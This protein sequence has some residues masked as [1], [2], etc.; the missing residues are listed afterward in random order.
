MP[1]RIIKESICTSCEVDSLSA[2]EERFFYRLL[3]SCDDFGRID[4]RAEILRAK[5][6]PLKL[7]KVANKDIT[8]WLHKLS[9]TNLVIVYDVDGKK[10][11]QF[12]T[13]DKHQQKR[14]KYSKYPA[15]DDGLITSDNI[16]NQMQS[17]VTENTRNENTRNENAEQAFECLWSLY[18]KKKGKGQVSTTQK[19]KLFKIGEEELTRCVDRYKNDTK[20][21]EDKFI[22][23]GS[24]F[25]NSGY[26]DYLDENYLPKKSA[27]PQT[28]E[29][30]FNYEE[31]EKEALRRVS[32][33]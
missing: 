17:N 20:N 8:K 10:Y 25:F 18:P 26:V 28:K 11:L 9:S 2:E 27:P 30:H 4:A 16:C 15:P 14:A 6:F 1:N 12:T 24:T 13:W 19:V 29:K 21:T 31:Y 32:E 23:N 33:L 3:V 22:Q 7:D 5:C